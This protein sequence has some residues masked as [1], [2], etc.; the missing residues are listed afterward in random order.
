M[1]AL[2]LTVKFNFHNLNN[3]TLILVK[4]KEGFTPSCY[5]VSTVLGWL[6]CGISETKPSFAGSAATVSWNPYAALFFSISSGNVAQPR[7]F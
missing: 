2:I 1:I 5:T 3:L 6:G 7:T 4:I